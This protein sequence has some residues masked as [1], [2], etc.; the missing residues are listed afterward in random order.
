MNDDIDLNGSWYM[1][2]TDEHTRIKD[3]FISDNSS[4]HS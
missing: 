3:C 2:E 1:P 4:R